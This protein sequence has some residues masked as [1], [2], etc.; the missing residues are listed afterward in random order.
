MISLIITIKYDVYTI[1]FFY[2]HIYEK[3]NIRMG[4]ILPPFHLYTL[5]TYPST[6]H[7]GLTCLAEHYNVTIKYGLI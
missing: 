4:T 1:A 5:S 6:P 7:A 2:I 3:L